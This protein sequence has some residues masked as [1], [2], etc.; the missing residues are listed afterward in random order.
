MHRALLVRGVGITERSVTNLMQRYEELVALRTTDQ[1]RIST[2]LK[3]HSYMH[4]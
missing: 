4:M 2:R 1:Q 3:Q